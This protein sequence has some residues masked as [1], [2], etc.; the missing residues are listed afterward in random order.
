[1]YKCFLHYELLVALLNRM[2]NILLKYI[3]KFRQFGKLFCYTKSNQYYYSLG[4][5]YVIQ[6]SVRINILLVI[7]HASQSVNLQSVNIILSQTVSQSVNLFSVSQS[8]NL[9]SVNQSV[10]QSVNQLFNQSVI[11]STILFIQPVNY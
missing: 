5:Y 1:M 7:K 6:H 9:Q 10:S 8:I 3:L 11:Q 4:S 2:N